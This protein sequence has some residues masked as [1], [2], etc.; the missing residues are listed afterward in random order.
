MK[1]D[2]FTGS[3]ARCKPRRR[4]WLATVDSP[5]AIEFREIPLQLGKG[6]TSILLH[7]RSTCG[8]GVAL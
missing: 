1:M 3:E 6:F 4:R 5:V 2:L 8:E 7:E